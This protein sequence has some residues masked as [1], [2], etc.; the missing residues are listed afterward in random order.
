M[1]PFV[2]ALVVAC[3][4]DTG[5]SGPGGAGAADASLSVIDSGVPGGPDGAPGAPDAMPAA[6][7]AMLGEP[8]A[9]CAFVFLDFCGVGP[10]VGDV[11][12]TSSSVINTDTDPRCITFIQPGGPDACLLHVDSLSIGAGGSLTGIGTRPL[13]VLSEGDIAIEGLLDVSSYRGGMTGAGASFASCSFAGLPQNDLGGAGGAA[14]G[15]FG[16]LGGAGGEGDTDTSLGFDGSA[17]A[18]LPGPADPLPGFVR[19]GCAGGKGGDEGAGGI[20]GGGGASGGAVFLVARG[21]VHVMATG[22]VRATGAGG[23]GGAVQAGGGGGGSGGMVGMEAPQITVSGDV[24]ANSGAGGG[25]GARIS[26]VPTSGGPG[27]DG[28][29]AVT[30]AGGGNGASPR[31]GEGD[32]GD[33]TAGAQIDGT[34]GTSSRIGAGGG[35]GSAGVVLIVGLLKG[36]GTVSPPPTTL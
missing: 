34:V 16:G 10:S 22:V 32:G 26:G 18:G 15:S 12:V 21:R 23:T 9:G 28:L 2:L 25:G 6:P 14:G 7:D 24:F 11:D 27:G 30:A 3:Q 19:G 29:A 1:A 13:I 20:G 5:G 35:G 8:D 17:A 36:S 31:A 4:F 33:G